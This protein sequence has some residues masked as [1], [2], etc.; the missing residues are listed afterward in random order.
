MKSSTERIYKNYNSPNPEF[1]SS[2]QERHVQLLESYQMSG[3][4]STS[5]Y[6]VVL[7]QGCKLPKVGKCA[8]PL[9]QLEDMARMDIYKGSKKLS[10]WTLNQLVILWKQ[11]NRVS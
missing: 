3:D 9:D 5:L 11:S 7:A 6:I 8:S 4:H 1:P 2:L 10:K